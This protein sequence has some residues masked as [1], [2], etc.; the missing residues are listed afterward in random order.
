MAF[1]GDKFKD[2]G[3][4]GREAYKQITQTD[5]TTAVVPYVALDSALGSGSGSSIT[6]GALTDKS[7]TITAGNTAQTLAAANA[8]RN[9]LL[10]QNNSTA[11]LWVN[12]GGIAAIVGQ[13]SYKIV[14]DGVLIFESNFIP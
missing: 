5:G 13:P 2:N 7:G 1:Q 9:Y 12:F 14:Q 10:I 8:T 3:P 6:R 4:A 11:D